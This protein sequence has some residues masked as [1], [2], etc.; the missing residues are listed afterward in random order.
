MKRDVSSLLARAARWGLTGCFLLG[1]SLGGVNCSQPSDPLAG[2]EGRVCRNWPRPQCDNGLE[3]TDGRCSSCGGRN[4]SCC[5][6]SGCDTGLTC[7]HSRSRD[8]NI[9]SACGDVGERCCDG[10]TRSSLFCNDGAMCDTSGSCVAMPTPG[11]CSGSVRFN[12]PV[13]DTNGCG[14]IATIT[15]SSRSSAL[16]CADD[17]GF[18]TVP[19]GVLS[20]Y[21]FCET[22]RFGAPANVMVTA[23]SS[24]DARRCAQ[25]ICINCEY[26]SGSCP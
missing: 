2:T 17:L 8:D 23:F 10:I 11:P 26:T 1:L 3:C 13:R 7:E 24:S 15:S 12:V 21:T 5:F 19:D 25:A 22:P 18:N 4:E 6:G 14:S 9:C 16:E 20:S